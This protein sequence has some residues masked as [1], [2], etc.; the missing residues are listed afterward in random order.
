MTTCFR[1]FDRK[2]H[3][4]LEF[5]ANNNTT[6]CHF[7]PKFCT[8]ILKFSYIFSNF[9]NENVNFS[10]FETIMA[11][12]YST[13]YVQ[14]RNLDDVPA[15]FTLLQNFSSKL[16][17]YFRISGQKYTQE[18]GTSRPNIASTPRGQGDLLERVTGGGTF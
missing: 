13:S 12:F 18:N 4:A 5:L 16:I 6:W 15:K 3:P 11:D 10:T 7:F 1:K 17:S 8:F 9:A 14:Q 2:T